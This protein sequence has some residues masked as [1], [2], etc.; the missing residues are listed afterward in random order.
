MLFL[1]AGIG[2]IGLSKLAYNY[3]TSSPT[4]KEELTKI[5]DEIKTFD[6]MK[7]KK[8][9]HNKKEINKESW[10]EEIKLKL[11]QKFLNA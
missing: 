2:L 4:K 9:I 10:S 11:N 7:L 5:C 1:Y 3:Y 8:V 6:H